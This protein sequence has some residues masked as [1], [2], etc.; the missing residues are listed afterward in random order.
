MPNIHIFSCQQPV[1]V[2][3]GTSGYNLHQLQGNK[4]HGTEKRGYLL[5][6]SE[7]KLKKMWQKRLCSVKEGS[8]AISHSDESKDPVRLNLLTCQVKL[9]PDD[10]GKKCFDL[11]S[12]SKNRTYHFQADDEF[13]MESWISVLNNAK[14]SVLLEAF[15]DTG[16]AS[17]MKNSVR[18]LRT[19]IM[20]EIQRLQGNNI[21]C[22]CSAADPEWLSTNLGV[23]ICLECCGIH[24]EMGVHISRTQS[25]IIDEIGTAQLLIARVMSNQGFND[26]FEATLPSIDVKPRPDSNIEEKKDFIRAKYERRRYVRQTCTNREEIQEDLR[27]AVLSRDIFQLLQVM[28]EGADLMAVLADNDYNETA[29]HLA[30]TQEEGSTL[31]LVDFIVQNSNS[32][33]LKRTTTDGN[34]ALHLCALYRQTECMK[35][36]LRVKP[37]LAVLENNSGKTALDIARKNG[38]QLCIDMLT[39]ALSGKTELFENVNIDWGLMHT[40]GGLDAVDYSDDELDEKEGRRSRPSSIVS[41]ESMQMP[42]PPSFQTPGSRPS[43]MTPAP[44]SQQAKHK[45]GITNRDVNLRRKGPAPPPPPGHT[46][47]PSDP[48][49]IR[50]IMEHKRTSSDP[51]PL[52]EKSHRKFNERYGSQPSGLAIFPPP[53]QFKDN[54]GRPKPA[55]RTVSR[56]LSKEV[57]DQLIPNDVGAMLDEGI[58]PPRPQPRNRKKIVSSVKRGRRCRAIYDCEADKEDELSFRQGDVILWIRED[59]E[60]K[61]WA[62]GEIEG[63]PSQ[64]G[65][66]PVSFVHMLND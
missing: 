58:D 44:P 64:R 8:L 56:A 39:H 29:L 46:R 41:Q 50:K 36:L 65:M 40:E 17:S 61:E 37:D 55:P 26:I 34:T 7:G 31:F 52:P 16:K 5:K 47:V 63:D 66:F 19:G 48:N 21:C 62:E 51:P 60:D 10:P 35:L 2:T 38:N 57:E 33:T 9:I 24:R 32:E 25:I 18:E 42:P 30:I 43:L 59:E 12:S 4:S 15:G 53:A 28:G 13:E 11:I 45:S 49:T 3:P 14:E 27:Q 20:K 54:N 6:R 1:G 22:D 23:L